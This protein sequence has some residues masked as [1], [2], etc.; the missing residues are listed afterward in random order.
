MGGATT[1]I[2]DGI[3]GK[4]NHVA[5][6]GIDFGFLLAHGPGPD[7]PVPR[8]LPLQL[9]AAVHHGG[10]GAEDVYDMRRDV[11]EKLGRLP[12]SFFDGRTHGE[13]MSRV[14]ND[15]DNIATTLQQSLMQIIT[16]ACDHRGGHRHDAHH[17]SPADPHHHRGACRSASSSPGSSPPGPRSISR[18]S[19]RASGQLNGHVEE[20]Y[21]GHAIVK[22]FG[23]ERRS[24]EKFNAINEKLY[25]ASWRAQFISGL[26]MPL[27]T[28]I[29][30]IGYV[31]R[32]RGGGGHGAS[33]EPSP[34]ATS[35][36]SSSTPGSS[37]CPSRRRPTSPTSCRAPSPRRSACSSSW[38]SRKSSLT[39]RRRRRLPT[40][41]AR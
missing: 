20:M 29:N 10:S 41:G 2:F 13:I 5:G 36:P 39:T 35:R 18:C 28:F 6:A 40:P 1:Q 26:M 14:T 24:I 11:S 32:R 38:T 16:S 12:L 4:I 8:E 31:A 30:N 19:G 27:M 21:T 3:M 9:P 17:Q 37:P 15:M 33:R 23:R 7:R 22:A 34:S 25:E